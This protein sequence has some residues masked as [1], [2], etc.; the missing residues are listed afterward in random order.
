MGAG[1]KAGN[2]FRRL[3]RYIP[4]GLRYEGESKKAALLEEGFHMASSHVSQGG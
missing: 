4:R 2:I 1:E 3:P